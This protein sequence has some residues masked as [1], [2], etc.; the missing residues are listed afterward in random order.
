[1][2]DALWLMC[3][4]VST[5]MMV[6]MFVLIFDKTVGSL[7]PQK[8]IRGHC[9]SFRMC[10]LN[11]QQP[12][13]FGDG[14]NRCWSRVR[15]GLCFLSTPTNTVRLKWIN[16]YCEHILGRKQSSSRSGMNQ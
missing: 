16:D 12:A 2:C 7:F 4:H 13:A 11:T 14:A 1:M 5:M 10:P 3:V 9:K 8:G 15:L 6:M